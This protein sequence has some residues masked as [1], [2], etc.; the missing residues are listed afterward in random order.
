LV[1]FK[2]KN[3]VNI[4]TEFKKSLLSNIKTGFKAQDEQILVVLSKI[5]Y[6]SLAVQER[7]EE[8]VKKKDLILS[9]MNNEYYLE[10]SCCDEK[11]SSFTT[12]IAY[13]E[14]EDSRITEYNQ[15]VDNLSKIISDIVDYTTAVL[16]YSPIN[17]KNIYPPIKK[18]F[19]ENTIYSAFIY[20]CNFRS[21]LP[22]PESILPLCNEKP[23]DLTNTNDNV[24]EVI[25]KLKE[26]GVSYSLESFL[27]M[28]QIISRSNIVNIET[29]NIVISSLRKFT[30]SLEEIKIRN[31]KEEVVPDKLI[32][33]FNNA[34][35]TFNIA[36]DVTTQQVKDLN[37]YLIKEIDMMKSELLDFINKNKGREVTRSKLN[38]V[39]HFINTISQWSSEKS[40]R[41]KNKI[42]ND[43]TFSYINFLKSFIDNVVNVF[44]N[45]ILNKVDYKENFIPKYLGLSKNHENNVKKII[46]DFYD[47]LRVFYDVPTLNNILQKIQRSCAD[48]VKLANNTPTFVTIKMDVS[49]SRNSNKE[50]KELK[51]IFDERTSKFLYEYYF[52]KILN[53]Y[54]DLSSQE[55]MIVREIKTKNIIDTQDIFSVEY[56]EET[57]TVIDNTVDTDS[58]IEFDTNL[59]SGDKKYLQQK[60]ANLLI[61]F[62][63][64]MDSYKEVVDISYEKIQDKIFKLKGKEKDIITDRL[65]DMTDEDRDADTILKINKLGVW[66]KGLQKGLTT[67]VKENYDEESEFIEQML[68]YERKA[69]KKQTDTNLDTGLDDFID[70]VERENEIERE[71]YDIS[72]YTEDFMDGVFEGDDVDNDHYDDYDS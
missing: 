72:G 47:K 45:I 26:S 10:N 12:T 44:P 70:E 38:E 19:S 43:A 17:T 21:L 71:A 64:I 40:Q 41:N 37:N 6:F 62:L 58:R 9:K 46:S 55:N 57:N 16:L 3:L 48:L 24:E 53:E 15:I 8:V 36:S 66:S 33:L 61:E 27:R 13:F 25:K 42:H 50:Q 4:S 7:I 63:R 1:P 39:K 49:S 32:E 35:D 60:V 67:Y 28:L 23:Y 52:L 54:I 34:M 22:I 69:Q 31:Q 20:Y 56:L 2:I 14:K 11:N 30:Y 5:I 18:E 68:Q 51:P 59:L 65:K 29:N